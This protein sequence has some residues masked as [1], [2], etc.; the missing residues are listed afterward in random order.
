MNLSLPQWA[1]ARSASHC[2]RDF[3][4]LLPSFHRFDSTAMKT[5]FSLFSL[6]AILSALAARPA[7][8]KEIPWNS[9]MS[10]RR[11]A[12]PTWRST[13][14]IR[15]RPIPTPRRKSWT[16]GTWRCRG[17]RRKRP[18]RPI[19]DAEA[20]QLTDGVQGP[21]RSLHQGPSRSAGG[22]PGGGPMVGRAGHGG[23]VPRAAGELRYRQGGKG[24]TSGRCPQDLPENPTAVRGG[25]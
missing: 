20:K 8:A 16:F 13:T 9:S 10:C 1:A 25:L 24:Q 11:K 18:S 19:S 15:S 17:A 6:L 7:A 3:S 14:S 5:T 12:T 21:A 2:R 22:D 23:P 4:F